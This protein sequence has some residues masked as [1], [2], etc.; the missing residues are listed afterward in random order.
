MNILNDMKIPVNFKPDYNKL[1]KEFFQL[2]K[3]PDDK[4]EF[5]MFILL[6]NRIT[7]DEFNEFKKNIMTYLPKISIKSSVIKGENNIFNGDK[8][9]TG[10]AS[11]DA[12]VLNKIKSAAIGKGTYGSVFQSKLTKY[13][14]KSIL[15]DSTIYSITP[16]MN[17][18]DILIEAFIQF[19]LSNDPYFGNSIPQIKNI[20]I[21]TTGPLTYIYIKMDHV[22]INY[23]TYLYELYTHDE[24]QINIYK[25]KYLFLNLIKTL[26][27]FKKYYGFNHNDLHNGNL[28]INKSDPTK[29]IIIDFG[30]SCIK[31]NNIVISPLGNNKVCNY[32]DMLLFITSFYESLAKILDSY[33]VEIISTLLIGYTQKGGLFDLFRY[34]FVEQLSTYKYKMHAVYYNRDFG[35]RTKYIFNQLELYTLY[36][37]ILKYSHEY[38]LSKYTNN[39]NN[40]NENIA[41][42]SSF[43]KR[44]I[45]NTT[46]KNNIVKEQIQILGIPM[47]SN[48]MDQ[49]RAAQ[50]SFM[51]DG[52][53]KSN[54]PNKGFNINL[55]LAQ[56]QPAQ[57]Q[58][59]KSPPRQHVFSSFLSNKKGGNKH[60][61]KRKLRKIQPRVKLLVYFKDWNKIPI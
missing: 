11:A 3:I 61:T 20:F 26:Y 2:C 46:R 16:K 37:E 24:E 19:V 1:I 52:H 32:D 15:L 51:V 31:N 9:N 34:L 44:R 29:P 59:K 33:F 47:Y 12:K 50:R 8:A 49:L 18:K 21:H 53:I 6:N 60:S 58:P 27:Y 10:D 39:S 35:D 45:N 54:N 48:N 40:S 25:E 17:C 28:M 36:N 13:I 14:Y 4:I 41:Q 38:N 55:Q 5:M 30:Y 7:L 57:Q 42:P 22:D 23:S 43:K 56:Q